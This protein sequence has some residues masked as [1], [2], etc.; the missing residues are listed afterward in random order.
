MSSKLTMHLDGG[1]F[2]WMF[3]V[4]FSQGPWGLSNVFFATIY[5]STLVTIYYPTL[6]FLWVLLL[7]PYQKLLEGPV[8]FKVGLYSI[9]GANVFNAF[10]QAL[11]IWDDHVSHTGSSNGGGGGL[12]AVTGG[13]GALCCVTNMSTV[14]TSSLLVA[15]YNFV[16]YFI[17]GPLRGLTPYQS[18]LEM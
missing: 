18:F 16:L 8:S 4:P 13:T 7:R 5:G 10:P 17:N 12:A 2:P 15:I 14:V 3:F 1:W 9:F 11:N 6:L